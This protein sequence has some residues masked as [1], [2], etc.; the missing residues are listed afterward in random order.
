MCERL[1]RFFLSCT[2]QVL[3][4]QLLEGLALMIARRRLAGVE[5]GSRRSQGSTNVSCERMRAA[6]H[7]SRGPFR[8]LERRHALAEIGE[9]GGG[10]RT[11]RNRVIPP[12]HERVIMTLPENASH[13]GHDFAPHR[14]GF[15]EAL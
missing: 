11:E 8:L 12:H 3:E 7:A 5:H 10:V 4:P 2:N 6:K 1:V 13:H 9:C 14:P 15:F